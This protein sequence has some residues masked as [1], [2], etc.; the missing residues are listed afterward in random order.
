VTSGQILFSLI[1]V[2]CTV[3]NLFSIMRIERLSAICQ[4]ELAA[5]ERKIDEIKK[6][7]APTARRLN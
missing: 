6:L 3:V 4:R 5:T 2:G 7:L 1:V